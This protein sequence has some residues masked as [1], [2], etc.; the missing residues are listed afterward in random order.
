LGRGGAQ[1]FR[2]NPRDVAT[3]HTAY[4]KGEDLIARAVE[5]GWEG[6]REIDAWTFKNDK[7]GYEGFDLASSLTV[8]FWNAGDYS[9]IWGYNREK[10]VYLRSM[11]YDSDGNPIPHKDDDTKE[12]I[13][14]KNLI[15]QFS[16]ESN[17]VGDEKGRLEYEL[18]GSNDGL[19]FLDGKVIPVTWNKED[20]DRRTKFYD[21]NGEEVRFIICTSSFFPWNTMSFSHAMVIPMN[22]CEGSTS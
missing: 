19:V 2:E 5:L 22:A 10:N 16:T 1:F 6:T 12:Q 4:A 7:E 9:A 13:T 21:L 15:I 18:I 3:E 11:G 17:I 20:R 8:D 14:V